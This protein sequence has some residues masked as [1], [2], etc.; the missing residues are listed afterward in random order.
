MALGLLVS[1]TFP[2]SFL[3]EALPAT[4]LPQRFEAGDRLLLRSLGRPQAC[5]LALLIPGLGDWALPAQLPS[6]PPEE[7]PTEL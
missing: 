6:S 7:A 4:P 2:C 5:S 3:R 1:R